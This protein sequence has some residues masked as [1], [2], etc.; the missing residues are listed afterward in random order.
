LWFNLA[1]L[2]GTTAYDQSGKENHGTIYG[3]RWLRGPIGGR[4]SFDGVDDYV[5]IPSSASLD[6]IGDVDKVT[7][8]VWLN[9]KELP[10]VLGRR[11]EILIKY[12]MFE[13]WIR[14]DDLI[15]FSIFGDDGVWHDA[16]TGLTTAT[17]GW[18]H[19]VA[20]T[21]NVEAKI[22]RDG[23]LDRQVDY[24]FGIA[25]SATLTRIGLDAGAGLYADLGL[26]RIYNRALSADEIKAHYYYC[27]TQLKEG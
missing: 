7:V 14:T 16:V 27:L 3:A 26:L 11:Y 12:G 13:F 19:L 5:E 4:L 25:T 8:E 23:K 15:I 20:L 9:L 24:N 6:G 10:S 18:M 22:F 17:K 21:D 1:T 2:Q